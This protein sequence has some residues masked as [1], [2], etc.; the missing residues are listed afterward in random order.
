MLDFNLSFVF[1]PILRNFISYVRTT[2]AGSK[3][4][5]DDNLNIHRI[6]GYLIS[7]DAFGHIFFHCLDFMWDQNNQAI[8]FTS[9][10]FATAPGLTGVFITLLMTVMYMFAMMQ[11]KIYT[12]F[13]RRFDGY[14]LFLRLHQ[15]WIPIYILL[16][17]HGS[18]FWQ[19]SVFP[20][21]FVALEK[22]IQSRRTKRDVKLVEAK[23]V[24]RDV[25]MVKMQ[26]ANTKKKFRYKAGQY[27]FLCCPAV[28]ER[29]YHPFTITSAPEDQF[30][31]CHI[32]CRQEMDWTYSLRTKLG[33]ANPSKSKDV[34]L[35]PTSSSLAVKAVDDADDQNSI[36][37][38]VDGPYGS[39]SE[40]VFDYD[41]A[42][43]VG[44]GIG[45]TPFISILKSIS[46][47]AQLF[48]TQQENL[49]IN[50]FWICRDQNEFDSFKEFFIEIVRIKFPGSLTL[51][52]YC[53]G[54]M[55]L[56]EVQ[57]A[58]YNQ[59]SGR[60]NWNRIFKETAQRHK[61]SEIGVFL[62]GPEAI[63]QQLEVA[64]KAH[65]SKRSKAVNKGESR[66]L[67]KF[68]KENF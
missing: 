57:A 42:I 48:H 16:W 37:L 44:A 61:G 25:L 5:L 36:L 63:A 10:L 12:V 19:F 55:N 49:N 56:K 62:C 66:T 53:T 35:Q 2:P 27:L 24:G 9:N 14:E 15:L 58:D 21:L 41:A 39:A 52:M 7:L 54:E 46:L 13:G 23:L 18:Q 60:P 50:F 8:P 20:L 4:P 28:N 1:I 11:R 45:V 38:K 34:Q 65:S 17:I 64:C 47:R 3:L 68:H 51:N 59:F 31:S 67:F 30:F 22:F 6:V 26:L 32:R 43:L 29:E 33:F 40:E